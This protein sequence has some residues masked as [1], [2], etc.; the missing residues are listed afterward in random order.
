MIS[1]IVLCVGGITMLFTG[2]SMSLSSGAPFIAG[3]LILCTM[4][5]AILLEGLLRFGK[6]VVKNQEEEAVD[7]EFE[8]VEK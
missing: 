4:A 3:G 6:T 5:A 1:S 8:E 7:A 2:G